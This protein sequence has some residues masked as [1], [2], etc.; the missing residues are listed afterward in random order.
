[1]KHNIVVSECDE[2][3]EGDVEEKEEIEDEYFCTFFSTVTDKLI[4]Q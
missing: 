4:Q 3:L 2:M 1:M